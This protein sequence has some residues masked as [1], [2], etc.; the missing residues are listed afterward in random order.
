MELAD[1][2]RERLERNNQDIWANER[3][4]TP[5]R[6][7]AVRLHLIGLSFREV[8]AVLDWLGVECCHQAVWYWKET[9]T[10]TQSD[11]PTAESSRVTSTRNRPKSM[12]EKK[13]LYAATDTE[14][15][16]L[17]DVYSR[18]GT[19]PAAFTRARLSCSPSERDRF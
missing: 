19:D 2:L 15:K 17:L 14:S 1:L 16:L 18:H 3:T 8:K 6:C 5:V 9:L 13:W 11:S 4:L 12:V 10:E 7:L